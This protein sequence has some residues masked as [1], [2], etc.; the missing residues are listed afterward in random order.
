MCESRRIVGEWNVIQCVIVGWNVNND[1]L[2][3]S[4]MWITMCWWWVKCESRCVG[5]EWNVNHDV[6]VVSEMWI[7][8]CCQWMKCESQCVVDVW[9]VNHDVLLVDDDRVW[10]MWRRRLLLYPSLLHFCR[11]KLDLQPCLR[12]V[13]IG[14][15]ASC[16]LYICCYMLWTVYMLLHVVN[17]IYVALKYK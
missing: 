10:R 11:G 8:M 16:E 1:V 5:G 12:S 17:C 4:E 3:V 14:Y 9:N 6:L 2:S 7:T 15:M 13:V